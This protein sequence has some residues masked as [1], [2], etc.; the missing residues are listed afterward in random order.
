MKD[1]LVGPAGMWKRMFGRCASFGQLAAWQQ[2]LEDG[3]LIP[4]YSRFVLFFHSFYW[5]GGENNIISAGNDWEQLLSKR[6]KSRVLLRFG[7]EKA[8]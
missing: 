8:Y 3:N 5:V 2:H 4:V 7:I 6:E 1:L